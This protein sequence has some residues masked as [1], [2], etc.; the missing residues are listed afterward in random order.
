MIYFTL[1]CLKKRLRIRR[2]FFVAQKSASSG[3]SAHS[4][5]LRPI[6]FAPCRGMQHLLPETAPQN[7]KSPSTFYKHM[8]HAIN[9]HSHRHKVLTMFIPSDL[10]GAPDF[11]MP[12]KTLP[13]HAQKNCLSR[14]RKLSASFFLCMSYKGKRLQ[15]LENPAIIC[16]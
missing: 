2:R 12:K 7:I 13:K 1:L 3:Q 6:H 14:G 4:L 10:Y 16:Q 5:Q 9:S 15:A 8:L 11:L